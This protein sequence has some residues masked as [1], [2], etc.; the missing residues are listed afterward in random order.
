MSVMKHK[1]QNIYGKTDMHKCDNN[2]RVEAI[3][4]KLKT[5]TLTAILLM[6]H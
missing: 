5:L 3:P 1:G 6:S 2:K 4:I